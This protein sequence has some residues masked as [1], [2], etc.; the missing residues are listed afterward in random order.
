MTCDTLNSVF[1][2]SVAVTVSIHYLT[3]LILQRLFGDTPRSLR[4]RAANGENITIIC[5]EHN[6]EQEDE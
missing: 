5:K 2:Q 3:L 4:K 6:K 1:P